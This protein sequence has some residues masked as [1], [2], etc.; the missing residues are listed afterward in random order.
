MVMIKRKE[1]DYFK[2]IKEIMSYLQTGSER[3]HNP[4]ADRDELKEMRQRSLKLGDWKDMK[5]K[6]TSKNALD[7][8]ARTITE[9]GAKKGER[10]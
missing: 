3:S 1:K 4:N 7:A 5:G 10:I 9:A 2:L 8:E 6:R